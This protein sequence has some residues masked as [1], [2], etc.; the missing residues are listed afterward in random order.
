MPLTIVGAC[1]VPLIY[2]FNS[3]FLG[4]IIKK[5]FP[6]YN[7]Q[8][9][10]GLGFFIFLTIIFIVSLPIFVS[11]ISF[12]GY[13]II[14]LIAQFFLLF[15]YIFNWKYSFSIE[16]ISKKELIF[17]IFI[18][19][20]IFGSWFLS[21][22]IHQA[23]S[24]S[25]PTIFQNYFSYQNALNDYFIKEVTWNSSVFTSNVDSNIIQ[26]CSWNSLNKLWIFL[27]QIPTTTIFNPY[28]SY[29]GNYALLSIYSIITSL[30]IS[31][32]FS[33][34]IETNNYFK[35]TIIFATIIS[36]NSC[37]F[38]FLTNSING[39]SWLIPISI[40]MLSTSFNS[41]KNLDYKL[42]FLYTLL[43]I[44]S[45]SMTQIFIVLLVGI[46][47][48]KFLS[49]IIAKRP[50]YLS[51]FMIC[52]LG[53]TLITSFVLQNISIIASLIV[54][55]SLTAVSEKL[56]SESDFFLASSSKLVA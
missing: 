54:S 38:M 8:T 25:T 29:F 16:L 31:G 2:F 11:P 27:F 19:L 41:I 55:N 10:I 30:I 39:I 45:Y 17:T 34:E 46:T 50:S 23:F 42:D 9:S 14:L 13:G 56:T 22:N 53:I 26:Y 20:A 49:T 21:N 18:F 52:S 7:I 36:L 51:S 44:A 6:Q 33:K 40:L 28:D 35:I 32:C 15:L 43:I 1:V 3:Y 48:V 37:L 24:L 12:L 47:I 5:I 4:K